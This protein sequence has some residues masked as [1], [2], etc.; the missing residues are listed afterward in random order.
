MDKERII[1]V[2][3]AHTALNDELLYGMKEEYQNAQTSDYSDYYLEQIRA[4]ESV[5]TVLEDRIVELLTT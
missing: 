4:V 5:L 3:I 2:C 1:N